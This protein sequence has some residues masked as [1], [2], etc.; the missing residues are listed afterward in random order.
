MTEVLDGQ[1][2]LDLDF[3]VGRTYQAHSAAPEEKTS[4]QS[5]KKLRGSQTRPPLYLDL[6]RVSGATPEWSMVTDGRLHGAQWMPNTTESP[7]DAEESFLS[8]I[9]QDTVPE[10]YFL[11]EKAC[12]GILR[13]SQKRG[14]TLPEVLMT[15]LMKQA[16]LS[17]EGF[18]ELKLSWMEE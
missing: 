6:R 18:E 3:G 13:R 9:L 10:K 16:G 2:T 7:R 15:A 17:S 1:M 8:Q 5:S 11:S 14:K 4:V 12:L